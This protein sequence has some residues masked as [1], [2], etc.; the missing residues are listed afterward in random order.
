MARGRNGA[1]IVFLI[2]SV[3]KWPALTEVL[4]KIYM[5]LPLQEAQNDY[6]SS[7]VILLC[8]YR[9]RD[10]RES[11][12]MATGCPVRALHQAEGLEQVGS[13]PAIRSR[14][15]PSA[16]ARVASRTPDRADFPDFWAVSF[17][18]EEAN[19]ASSFLPPLPTGALPCFVSG[20][21]S[22]YAAF[23]ET[24]FARCAGVRSRRIRSVKLFELALI[25]S[26]QVSHRHNRLAAIAQAA[27]RKM[28]AGR[29][30][31]K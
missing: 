27:T 3:N 4:A 8:R 23:F 13:V 24:S 15:A 10:H 21:V 28:D 31:A 19:L 25:S 9:R 1:V 2:A 26:R 17:A 20:C 11:L 12:R 30:G 6:R 29:I 22:S 5:I 7:F 14:S 18:K 16:L